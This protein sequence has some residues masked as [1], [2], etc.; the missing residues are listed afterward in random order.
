MHKDTVMSTN[1]SKELNYPAYTVKNRD[2]CSESLKKKYLKMSLQW[3]TEY[4]GLRLISFF[5]PHQHD[6]YWID[7]IDQSFKDRLHHPVPEGALQ[8]IHVS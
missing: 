6:F 8:D 3:L 4:G 5:A 2:V 1:T 7:Q